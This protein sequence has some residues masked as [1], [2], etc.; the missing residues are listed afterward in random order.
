[1][2]TSIICAKSTFNQIYFIKMSKNEIILFYNKLIFTNVD[3]IIELYLIKD[4]LLILYIIYYNLKMKKLYYLIIFITIIH[5][6]SFI[7]DI[8]I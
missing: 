7:N 1:M 6:V 8:Y 2:H 3:V 5:K 4:I